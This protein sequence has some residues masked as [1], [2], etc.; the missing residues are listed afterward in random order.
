MGYIYA[1]GGVILIL[2]VL[3]LTFA[4]FPGAADIP[5]AG[6]AIGWMSANSLV[7]IFSSVFMLTLFRT[8]F[9]VIIS[10][11]VAAAAAGITWILLGGVI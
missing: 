10:F 11:A 3:S 9:N 4:S 1:I 8:G 7:L 6:P 2:T 5:V